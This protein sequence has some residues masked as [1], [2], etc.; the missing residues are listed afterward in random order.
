MKI[1]RVEYTVQPEYVEQNKANIRKVMDEVKAMNVAGFKYWSQLA[2]DGVTFMHM[3][4][5]EEGVESP[6]NGMESFNAFRTALKGS[7]PVNPPKATNFDM[8]G[9]GFDLF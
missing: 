2:E 8:V 5:S 1:I 6:L 9:A 7:G 4:I 3:A